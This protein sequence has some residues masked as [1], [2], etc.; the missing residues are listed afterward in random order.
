MEREERLPAAPPHTSWGITKC[1]R[2][3]WGSRNKPRNPLAASWHAQPRKKQVTFLHGYLDRDIKED[4]PSS[5]QWSKLT[6]FRHFRSQ[7]LPAQAPRNYPNSTELTAAPEALPPRSS[8]P[9]GPAAFQMANP[10]RLPSLP[11]PGSLEHFLCPQTGTMDQL[12][13]VARYN[14]FLGRLSRAEE[15][16]LRRLPQDKTRI[17]CSHLSKPAGNTGVLAVPLQ[18]DQNQ[19]LTVLHKHTHPQQ[20]PS[21]GRGRG[22]ALF[23]H[24]PG[25]LGKHHKVKAVVWHFDD[26]P[27]ISLK[28]HQGDS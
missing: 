1:S 13:M 6:G 3:R 10:S 7:D 21:H 14:C 17:F 25:V 8:V 2:K 11:P 19:D 20:I 9:N 5:R 22:A 24:V 16:L 15:E 26:F 4:H 28:S 18:P 23:P 12:E 27:V